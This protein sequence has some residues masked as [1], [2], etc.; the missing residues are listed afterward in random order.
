MTVGETIKTRRKALRVTQ[1]MLA[2]LSGKR[3]KTQSGPK[4][5][6]DQKRTVADITKAQEQLGYSPTT[7][8]R[9]GLKA[10]LEWQMRTER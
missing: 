9:D 2:E 4:R 8:I 3:P 1:P 5:P 6:G 10:Q 7:S